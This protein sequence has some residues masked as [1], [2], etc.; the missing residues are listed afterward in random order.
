MAGGS[1]NTTVE[2]TA[3]GGL[4]MFERSDGTRDGFVSD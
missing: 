4:V 2:I 3:C 1:A